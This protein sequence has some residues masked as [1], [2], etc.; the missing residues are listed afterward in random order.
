MFLQLVGALSFGAVEV[1]F[2]N[3]NE[4][5]VFEFK[6]A[7]TNW[8]VKTITPNQLYNV[9]SKDETIPVRLIEHFKRQ[10]FGDRKIE[11]T[12]FNWGTK[13][14]WLVHTDVFSYLC[15]AKTDHCY[16]VEHTASLE[17]RLSVK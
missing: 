11:T 9:E 7:P 4:K 17:V 6:K 3:L 8:T 14:S 15:P 12:K 5:V 2:K 10:S 1:P 13:Y 16:E